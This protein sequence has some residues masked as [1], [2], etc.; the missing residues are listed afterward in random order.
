M[1]LENMS[2]NTGNRKQ[3]VTACYHSKYRSGNGISLLISK[4][5]SV[6]PLLHVSD[7]KRH[8]GS[9]ISGGPV[10]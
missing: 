8:V 7:R 4:M 9:L 5:L 1:K 6:L 3:P 10:F 2:G